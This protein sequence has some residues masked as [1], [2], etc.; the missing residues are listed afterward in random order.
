MAAT[1]KRDKRWRILFVKK[2]KSDLKW[3]KGASRKP[4]KVYTAMFNVLDEFEEKGTGYSGRIMIPEF[5]TIIT[6]VL[7][8][9]IKVPCFMR[10]RN[11]KPFVPK[12][13]ITKPLSNSTFYKKSI[14]GLKR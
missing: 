12:R 2:V 4:H 6:I 8:T 7:S 10:T 13:N 3:R 9:N 1:F 5:Q 11:F 14:N